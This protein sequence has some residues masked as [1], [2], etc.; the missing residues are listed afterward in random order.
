MKACLLLIAA[1]SFSAL[2]QA[3]NPYLDTQGKFKAS[4]GLAFTF[5]A[6]YTDGGD[7]LM[8]INYTDGTYENFRL[9]NRFHLGVGGLWENGQFG[10]AL[11][12]GY[13]F[14]FADDNDDNEIKLERYTLE[15]LPYYRHG[16]HKFSVGATWHFKI[17]SKL[18]TALVVTNDD[19][20]TS[21]EPLHLETKF[22]DALGAVVQYDYQVTQHNWLGFRYV[23]INYDLDSVSVNHVAAQASGSTDA[24]HYGIFYRVVF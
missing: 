16:R 20:S 1:L 6:G 22:K 12:L 3:D 17:Q 21:N 14:N 2:A 18:D 10:T 7:N 23:W 19:G 9:G 5:F 8:R 15:L 11:N 13:M 4:D 24:N